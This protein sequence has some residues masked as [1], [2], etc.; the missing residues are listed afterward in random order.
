MHIESSSVIELRGKI[1]Q[2]QPSLIIYNYHPS[3]LPWVATKISPKLYRSN[4]SEID[5]PQVG[6]IHEVTQNIADAATNYKNRYITGSSTKLLNSLFDFY[7][8]PDPTLLLKNAL[9]FKTGRLIPT[10]NYIEKQ[11]SELTIGSFGFGTNNKGFEKI[12]SLVQKEF[13]KAL[14]RLNIPIADFGDETG[15]N[16]KKISKDCYS[17]IKNPD[18]RL[19]ITHTFFTNEE[20]LNFL[21]G[22]SINI[23][24]YT[25]TDTG[26]RGISSTTDYALAVKRP[27]AISNSKMFRHLFDIEPSIC[28][29]ENSLKEILSN[30]INPLQKKYEEYSSNN[31]L[32]EYE[33]II[34]TIFKTHN[35]KQYTKTG[36]RNKITSFI[37]K[38]FTKPDNTFTW[39]RNSEKAHEDVLAA[40]FSIEYAPIKLPTNSRFNRILDDTAREI[41]APAIAKLH[42]L[43]PQTMAKKIPEANVQ[44]AFVFDT[45]IRTIP[46]YKNPK[47]LC[48][49]SYEDTASMG[50]TK[51]GYII[52]EIDPMLNY[53]LQ[54]YI[55]K[56]NVQKASYDIIFSTSV[57]EH[58]P[59][60]ESFIKCVHE[61]LSP[62]GTAIITCDY[63]DG[64]KP[65]DDKPDVDA[66]FYTKQDLTERLLSYMP[67]TELVD[68][69]DWDC[70]DP[71]FNYL[72]KYQYT[73]ATFVVKKLK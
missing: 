23:F 38:T 20:L 9:V 45:V 47:L 5:I 24:L 55:T 6:I 22:N 66:R 4:I 54:D 10:Y 59:D 12:V 32:W 64:W 2:H 68:T 26:N 11:P 71:D 31:I 58:D 60:D 16:A 27:I 51:M 63:K 50:L 28:V 13:D 1:E 46:Q 18:I 29:Q 33:R 52:E 70:P 49:G 14:I 57:I 41:Y 17:L 56:P 39:L 30:G 65:G 43:A 19:E 61:L 73:F 3:V 53:F 25:D 40:D 62:G 21:S 69:P 15:E 8:A 44:Q 42:S 34:N 72:G 48:I 37:N 67:N 36:I 7:I 35:T